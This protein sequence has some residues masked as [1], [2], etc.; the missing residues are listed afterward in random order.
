MNCRQARRLLSPYFDNEVGVKE[1]D[2]IEKHLAVCPACREELEAQRKISAGLQEIYRQVKAPPGF[3]TAVMARIEQ[4]A[5]QREANA[6]LRRPA[7]MRHLAAA[8]AV[9]VLAG[10]TVVLAY[11]EGAGGA[12][13]G[14]MAWQD[15]SPVDPPAVALAPG[16]QTQETNLPGQRGDGGKAPKETGSAGKA[17]ALK[18]IN[19]G[20][21]TQ[22]VSTRKTNPEPAKPQQEANKGQ[23]SGQEPEVTSPQPASQK[24]EGQPARVFLSNTRHSRS[25]LLKLKVADLPAVQE[26][27]L[28]LARQAGAESPQVVWVWQKEETILRLVVPVE[29]AGKLIEE[30]ATLGEELERHQETND[31]TAE[32]NRKLAEYHLLAGQKEKATASAGMLNL[33]QQ[34]LAALEKESLEAGHEIVNIWLIAR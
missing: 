18:D 4:Q 20:R 19:E 10:G 1:R 2:E 30:V 34:Q 27:V 24:Q 6:A 33:L 28:A 8:A 17:A 25:T 12:T 23:I 11:K 31:I 15:S 32:Y 7:W 29:A 16:E 5:R 22:Q 3:S 26:K 13:D 21:V 9:A 14:S